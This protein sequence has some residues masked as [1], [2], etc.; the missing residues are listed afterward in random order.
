MIKETAANI[1][2]L[3]TKYHIPGLNKH[4]LTRQILNH[5]LNDSLSNKLTLITAPAGY[6]KTTAVLKWLEIIPHPTAWLSLDAGDNEPLVFWRYFYA[7]LD[8]ILSGIIKDAEYVFT[9]QELLRANVHLSILIDNLADVRSDFLLILDDF[10]FVT[11]QSILN[12]LSYLMNYLPANLHLILISR[13]APQ[14]KLAKLG[15]KEDLVRIEAKDLRFATEEIYHYYRARGYFLQKEEVQRIE[16]YT[17]GWAAALVAVTMSLEDEKYRNHLLSNLGT[18]N[19]QIENFLDEDVFHMWTKEQQDFMVKTSIAE[20]LCGSLCE[21]ITDYDGSRLLKELYDQNGFLVALDDEGTWFRYHHLF[22]DFLRKKLEK[23]D[24]A[25]IQNLHRRAGEWLKTNGFDNE[26]IEH[27]L[28]GTHYEEALLLIERHGGGLLRR[29]E[30]TPVISWIERLPDNYSG[31]S[32]MILLIKASYFAEINDT[33][34]AWEC[35]KKSELLLDKQAVLFE[36]LRGVCLMTKA[37]LFFRQGDLANLFPVINEAAA[38]GI[39]LN[40]NKD[41][42]DFNLYDISIY[43]ATIGI[44]VKVFGQ[45]LDVFYSVVNSYRSLITVNP[46]Y[47][48]LVEGEF[49][50][51]NDRMD[52]ALPKLLAS[53]D[54]AINA[55]CPGAL[56][57]AMVTIAKI[58]RAQGDIDGAMEVIRECENRVETFHKPHWDYMLKAFK[59]RLLIDLNDT[60]KLDKWLRGSRLSLYQFII[61]T[62]EYELIVLARVLIDKKRYGDATILLNRL[63]SFAEGLKRA[64]SIVEITSL[65]AIT[66]INNSKEEIAEKYLETALRIG[67]EE[68]YCRSFVDEFAPMVSLLE[69]YLSR[70]KGEDKLT[71]YARKLLEQTKDSVRHSQLTKDPDTIQ[72]LLTPKE[73]KILQ[74]IINAYDNKKIALEL[75]I[76]TRTVKAHTGSIYHKLDVKNRVQCLKKILGRGRLEF[77]VNGYNYQ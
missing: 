28:Q 74:M 12:E 36:S 2:L 73:Q 55:N 50:Y 48:P 9:S 76:T 19:L 58:R 65:L 71:A 1:G 51:E 26:S 35:V 3:K 31:N 22:L 29:G 38:L 20:R 60:E 42:M 21:A 62:R 4:L 24:A 57:P 47:A 68:G 8:S 61:R 64:H 27:F 40:S 54:E 37:N 23:S 17:E 39:T 67:I 5:K 41:Y 44:Y 25:L 13:T 30:Y 6:G 46:G 15:L 34:S 14:L 59:V 69:M 77:C 63:L 75:G 72:K 56:V 11:S 32:P 66:A 16:S 49:H 10:H 33:K 18:C 52:E 7:A 45:N 70:H 53:V 43:R